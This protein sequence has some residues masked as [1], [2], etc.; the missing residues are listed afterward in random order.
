MYESPPIHPELSSSLLDMIGAAAVPL[1]SVKSESGVLGRAKSA[2]NRIF[3][4][5]WS[6][7]I[8]LVKNVMEPA[9]AVEMLVFG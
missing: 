3:K 1:D 7:R 4:P 5:A 9:P 6:W 8:V 2:Q